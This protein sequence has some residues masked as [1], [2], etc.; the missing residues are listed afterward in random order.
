[1]KRFEDIQE[2][3]LAEIGDELERKNEQK[4]QELFP[5]Y[6]WLEQWDG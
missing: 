3:K 5:V 4:C 1:M 6:L 2:K